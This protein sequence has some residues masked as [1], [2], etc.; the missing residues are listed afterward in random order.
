[1]PNR[2]APTL[3]SN[4]YNDL[5]SSDSYDEPVFEEIDDINYIK[6]INTYIVVPPPLTL[7]STR[8]KSIK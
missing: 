5:Y 2:V 7:A 3:T 6:P 1:M 8:T 4:G